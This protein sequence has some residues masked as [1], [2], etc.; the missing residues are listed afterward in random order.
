M[1]IKFLK[2]ISCRGVEY[3]VGQTVDASTF[4]DKELKVIKSF[5]FAVEVKESK[6]NKETVKKSNKKGE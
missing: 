1:K 4:T 3:L 5:D 6:E 2:Q